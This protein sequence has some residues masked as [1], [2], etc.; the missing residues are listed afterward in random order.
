M[1]FEYGIIHFFFIQNNEGVE[2]FLEA[3]E[4]I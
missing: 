1:N 3:K 2:E 4:L